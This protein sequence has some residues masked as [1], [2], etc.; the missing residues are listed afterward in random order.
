MLEERHVHSASTEG[1]L[2]TPLASSP[3]TLLLFVSKELFLTKSN[4][5]SSTVVTTHKEVNEWLFLLID[6]WKYPLLV[7][8]NGTLLYG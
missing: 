4:R 2:N 3:V 5:A 1:F 6:N 8:G 7:W